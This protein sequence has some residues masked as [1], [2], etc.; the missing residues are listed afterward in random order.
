MAAERILV[1][2]D[3]DAIREIVCSMLAA[4]NY[5]TKQASSGLKALAMLDAGEQFELMLSDLMMADLDGIGLLERTKESYPD[6]PVV[7][8]TAVHDISVALAAI[9]N[10]AYDYLLKP[11]ER[12][13]LLA[14]VR[15]ALENRHLKMQ[16]R[17]YQTGLE[18]MVEARTEQLQ[19]AMT[20][21]ERSYGMTLEALGGALDL[22]DAETEGHSRRVTVFTI[23][24]ARAMGLSKDQIDVIARGAFLHDIGKMAIP[25]AILRK[26]GKLNP[27]EVAIMREHCYHGY[28]ILKKIPFLKEASEIVYAH[29]EHYDG[30]GY[31]RQLKGDE[32]P[33]GARI[34][35]VADT[36]DAITSDRPYRAAQTIAAARDEIKVW[37]GRQFDPEVVEVFISMPEQI[38]SGLRKDVDSQVNRFAYSTAKGSS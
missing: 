23:A 8:V 19:K 27:D 36:L 21:L 5:K 6:M 4:A 17:E 26:P 2:D 32:I 7:M 28:Q 34:F 9:R 31:P 11:F 15:R 20:D 30:S 1:V 10:G 13:Q 38:W 35:S 18:R 33:L 24:I 22:K 16:N 14:T 37:S 29:Q 25:D 3:E 12:E